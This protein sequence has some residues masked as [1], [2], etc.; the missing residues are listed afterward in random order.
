MF[1][2]MRATLVDVVSDCVDVGDGV[3]RAA[4]VVAQQFGAYR[5]VASDRVFGADAVGEPLTVWPLD[6]P[7]Y[8]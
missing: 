5:N 1:A 4:E 6:A 2:P 8:V 7:R 3:G